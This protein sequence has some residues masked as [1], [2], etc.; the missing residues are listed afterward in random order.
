MQYVI[1][2]EL[3]LFTLE[4]AFTCS[5]IFFNPL[6]FHTNLQV[7]LY[8]LHIS[9]LWSCKTAVMSYTS[10]Y[11]APLIQLSV[12]EWHQVLGICDQLLCG[13]IV[14]TLA[15]QA[16]FHGCESHHREGKIKISLNLY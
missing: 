14:S 13:Q 12:Y 15:S 6:A 10:W 3:N 4:H 16:E 1:K 11:P 9:V 7:L 5:A 8:L 2:Y